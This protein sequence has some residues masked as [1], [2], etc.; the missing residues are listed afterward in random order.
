MVRLENIVL[1]G[2]S[3]SGK[4]TIGEYL[5]NKLKRPHIDTDKMIV[6]N[7]GKS[8]NYIFENH[9]EDYFRQLESQIIE[10]IQFEQ[11]IIISTGG[12]VVLNRN[13]INILKRNG[14]IFFLNGSTQTLYRNLHSSEGYK[15]GRPL[16][17]GKDLMESLERIYSERQ[18]LYYSSGDYEI[19]IDNKSIEEIGDEII[20]VFNE[21]PSCS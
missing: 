7:S 13:N 8:I 1:V 18:R 2:M 14:I 19:L 11:G 3:G 15:D 12:G 9:G 20:K 10:S 16:L 17:G 5:A 21:L 4:S 6:S